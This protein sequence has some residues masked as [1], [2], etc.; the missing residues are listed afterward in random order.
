MKQYIYSDCRSFAMELLQHLKSDTVFRAVVEDAVCFQQEVELINMLKKMQ[1][2]TPHKL[3][4]L[5][6]G[7]LYW[8]LRHSIRIWQPS[9][10]EWF[11]KFDHERYQKIVNLR[12]Q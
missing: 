8:K 6:G 4:E 1:E 7:K 2:E 5:I 12:N 10:V 11:D 3:N 9:W